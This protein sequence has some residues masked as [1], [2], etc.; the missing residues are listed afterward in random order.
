MRTVAIIGLMLLAIFTGASAA[1]GYEVGQV[2]E[3]KATKPIGVPL[4]REARS[5][6]FD[7]AQTGTK[8]TVIGTAKQG[9][10]LQLVLEDGRTA[11]IVKKYVGRVVEPDGNGGPSP[12]PF[13]D[14]L[15]VWSS[16]SQCEAVVNA[17]RRMP[18]IDGTLRLGTWNIRWFPDGEMTPRD[19]NQTLPTDT[20]WL[21]CV[22]AWMDIDILAIQEIRTH[23]R[24]EEA[25][26]T[27]ID[28]LDA[29][30]GGTWELGLQGCGS[31]SSQHVGY[32]WNTN[33]VTLESQQDLWRFNAKATNGSNA[34][35][36][37]RRP[38]HYALAKS[39]SES[40]AD[41]HIIT[42]HLKSGTQQASMESRK[43]SLQHI[44]QSVSQ[45]L[46][47]DQDIVIL[48]DFNTMGVMNGT[49]AQVEISELTSTVAAENPGF[50]HLDIEPSCTEYYAGHGG[51]LDHV[52]TSQSMS[53]AANVT[54]KVTGYCAVHSCDRL[55]EDDMPAAYR[56][57]SDHCPVIV[58][59]V[60]QDLD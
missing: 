60:D 8:G 50:T 43:T 25:W 9:R 31:S 47:A 23:S 13:G 6:L 4:H 52:L 20:A 32:L 29:R 3:L 2:V 33:H 7:R 19:N 49:S 36:N 59:V 48:G 55:D 11:W 57:L 51:W 30:T 24:A 34:C 41:F 58:D 26:E 42:V 21:A 15:A 56:S 10:W 1:A 37:N 35:K 54:A 16:L 46:Q 44:D 22:I 38:G 18:R 53:E 5:S 39:A 14:E 28:D 17:G 40:G 45:F 27:I 12:D